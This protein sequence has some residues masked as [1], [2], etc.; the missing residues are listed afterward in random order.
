MAVLMERRQ[1]NRDN[2]TPLGA[3]TRACGNLFRDNPDL[4]ECRLQNAHGE[5]GDSADAWPWA[6]GQQR[7]NVQS[8]RYFFFAGGA[9][10]AGF[11]FQKAGSAWTISS[12][13]LLSSGWTRSTSQLLALTAIS[14]TFVSC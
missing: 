13:G 1:E 12:G 6:A 5:S 2:G 7:R 3:S 9:A 11:G 14:L 8:R 4:E 10:I